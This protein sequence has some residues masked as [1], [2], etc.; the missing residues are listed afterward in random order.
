[1]GVKK[2]STSQQNEKLILEFGT[3]P[4]TLVGEQQ[5]VNGECVDKGFTSRHKNN[6]LKIF[7]C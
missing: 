1:L 4:T 5:E 6:N 3:G 7:I 2:C